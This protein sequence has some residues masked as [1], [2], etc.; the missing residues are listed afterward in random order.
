M[1]GAY[2]KID[3]MDYRLEVFNMLFLAPHTKLPAASLYSLDT[4]MLT[5]PSRVD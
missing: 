4:L 5:P 2:G 1:L 3:A